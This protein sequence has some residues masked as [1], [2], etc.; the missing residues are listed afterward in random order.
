MS[1]AQHLSWDVRSATLDN[2]D[3]WRHLWSDN[4][5]AI[6]GRQL[7]WLFHVHHQSQGVWILMLLP[8]LLPR[9]FHLDFLVCK[10]GITINIASDCY[11]T[12]KFVFM[13]N[14]Q[15][16]PWHLGRV[17]PLLSC[18]LRTWPSAPHLL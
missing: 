3:Q 1:L 11:E 5:R 6:I 16:N 9:L 18:Y 8:L 13:Q 12:K 10:T 17:P 4:A 14:T 15:N 7:L 2:V